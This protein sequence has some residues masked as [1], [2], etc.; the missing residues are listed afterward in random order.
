M[1]EETGSTLNQAALSAWHDEL[2]AAHDESLKQQLAQSKSELLPRFTEHYQALKSLRRSVRRALQRHWK[3]SLAGVALL[4]ALG[5]TP[6]FAATIKVGGKCTLAHAIIAANTNTTAGGRCVRGRGADSIV[7]PKKKTLQLRAPNN[8]TYG[9]T[10]LPTVRSAIT[11]IGNGST[12]QRA[13]NAPAFRILAVGQ[14]GSLTL[15]NTTVSGGAT[16]DKNAPFGAGSKGGAIY[17]NQGAVKLLKSKISGNSAAGSGGGVSMNGGTLT[18]AGNS[19]LSGNSAR[20]G[21]G[22]VYIINHGTASVTHSTVSGNSARSGGGILLGTEGR[23]TITSTAMFGNSVSMVGGGVSVGGGTVI[24]NRSTISGN[25]S[26]VG[27]GGLAVYPDASVAINNS[28]ISRNSSDIGGGVYI[29]GGLYTAGHSTVTIKNTTII[30]NSAQVWAVIEVHGHATLTVSDSTITG[31]SAREW[32]G[33]VRVGR[34]ATLNLNRTIVSGN[35]GSKVPEVYAYSYSEAPDRAHV[36]AGNFN[37]FGHSGSS[38][39]NFSSGATDIV[40]AQPLAQIIDP[41][42]G[43]PVAGSPAID[44]INNSACPLNDRDQ[45]GALRNVGGTCDVGAI[46]FGGRPTKPPPPP[47][48]ASAAPPP[49][50]AA[51]ATALSK[52]APLSPPPGEAPALPP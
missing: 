32:W 29:G 17:S 20:H 39:T 30:G 3:R 15:Q 5:V 35:T 38:G 44:A 48:T 34:N 19:T 1:S 13:P 27:G 16:V 45:R 40:P 22:G 33:G 46:E 2:N 51:I 12:I 42:T 23:L 10:G 26:G 21:G 24:L 4:L 18:V 31:N 28:H 52:E 25:D 14:T 7:L 37:I 41:N 9:P 49:P 47:P 6:A 11:I 43:E 8:A 36:H 50:A